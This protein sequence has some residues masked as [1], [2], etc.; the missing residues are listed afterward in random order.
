MSLVKLLTNKFMPNWQKGITVNIDDPELSELLNLGEVE[1]LE[2]PEPK[3]E[4]EEVEEVTEVVREEIIVVE[5]KPKKAKKK[6]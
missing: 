2:T 1:L 4:V 3:K 5:S 6:V